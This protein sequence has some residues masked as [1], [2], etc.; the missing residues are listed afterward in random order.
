MRLCCKI[1][2]YFICSLLLLASAGCGTYFKQFGRILPE[3]DVTNAFETYQI[4]SAL[5]Y[6]I[7]GSDACPNAIIGLHRTYSLEST[8]WKQVEMTSPRL[9]DLVENMQSMERPQFGFTLFDNKG[10][11]IGVWY[12][13]LT[14]PTS[15]R[16]VNDHAVVIPTPDLDTYE[17]FH[18]GGNS[19]REE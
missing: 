15:I 17:S 5:R 6:Y 19:E 8:L 4:D 11:R 7:S 10:N 14:A 18:K 2:L 12:S 13:I 9:R 16:M 3:R 1:F